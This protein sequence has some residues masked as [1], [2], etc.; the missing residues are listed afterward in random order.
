MLTL[1]TLDFLASD[2]GAQLLARLAGENLAESRTLALLTALRKTYT[3]EQAGAALE[4]ARLRLKATEKFGADAARLFFTRDALEQ[5][6][7]L[8]IRHYR[9]QTV[10]E[11]RVVDAG[12]GIG[13]DSLAFAQHGAD[14]LGLDLDPVRIAIA[15]YNAS[16]LNLPARFEVADIRNGL[17]DGYDLIFFDPARRDD[18]GK[19]IYDVE[20]YH[21][22]LSIVRTWNVPRKMVKISPGV[23]LEQLIS[24][25]GTVEFI[26]ADG[27]LKEAVLHLGGTEAVYQYFATLITDDD[28]FHWLRET[29]PE[30][31]PMSEPRLWLI[32][33]DA[34]LLRAGLVQDFAASID[35][36]QLDQT[37]AYLTADEKPASVWARVWEIVDWMP[38]NL[39][40]LRAYLR[41]KNVGQVTVK[42][43][44]SPITPEELISQLKLKG[45]TESRTLALTRHEGQPIII[46]CHDRA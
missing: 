35:A 12:C 40:K 43:R 27:D 39:K 3:A 30:T 33:P 38:F 36:Y 10:G 15:R 37:I 25:G 24:F 32:E 8:R 16:A 22:P 41:E 23:E 5:A 45:G 7:D 20:K 18:R 42:K 4:M 14:V 6:S 46:I 44:G 19:R 31:R 11:L 17:P 29:E 2:N 13:A 1:E 28:V 26:S 34:A 9:A 21:P